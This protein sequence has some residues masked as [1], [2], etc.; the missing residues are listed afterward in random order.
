M[1]Y[2]VSIE[3]TL[4]YIIEVEAPNKKVAMSLVLATIDDYTHDIEDYTF[5]FVEEM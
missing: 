2:E 3:K 1:K 5:N 4:T